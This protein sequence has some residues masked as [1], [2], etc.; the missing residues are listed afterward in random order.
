[1]KKT[2]ETCGIEGCDRPTYIGK[3]KLCR[4]H[5]QNYYRKGDPGIGKIRA[6]KKHQPYKE[7][8]NDR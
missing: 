6:K 2:H 1:M 3:H 8:T 7:E 5:L 4:A